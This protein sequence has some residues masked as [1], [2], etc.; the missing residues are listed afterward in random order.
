M[1]D[2]PTLGRRGA[3]DG[4]RRLRLPADLA[5]SVLALAES[6]TRRLER[7]VSRVVS[8]IRGRV[9]LWETGLPHVVG[10]V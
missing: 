7:E 1:P 4:F 8:G 9:R 3:A 2:H 10:A 6:T 5:A